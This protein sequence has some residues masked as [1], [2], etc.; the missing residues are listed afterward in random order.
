MGGKTYD[1]QHA[2]TTSS[3]Q[4][5]ETSFINHDIPLYGKDETSRGGGTMG[6]HNIYQGAGVSLGS[7]DQKTL[8]DTN[9]SADHIRGNEKP[10][11]IS[12]DTHGSIFVQKNSH[13]GIES[14]FTHSVD[15]VA[16]PNTSA[17]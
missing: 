4:G 2:T 6:T 3:I 9:A 13:L 12:P 7:Y 5:G 11:L 16:S 10:A 17:V 15:G 8:E 14:D 1:Y